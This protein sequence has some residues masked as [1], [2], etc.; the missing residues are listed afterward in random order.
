MLAHSKYPESQLLSEFRKTSV[1]KGLEQPSKTQQRY[2]VPI[3]AMFYSKEGTRKPLGMT[4][5]TWLFRYSPGTLIN[6][7]WH[8]YFQPHLGIYHCPQSL[9]LEKYSSFKQV[10]LRSYWANSV[11]QFQNSIYRP[12]YSIK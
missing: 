10:F 5:V 12:F 7:E 6:S 1:Q 8:S 3:E 9:R 4:Y 11:R 2:V